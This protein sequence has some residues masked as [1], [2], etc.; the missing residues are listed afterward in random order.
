MDQLREGPPDDE[1]PLIHIELWHEGS[2]PAGV[3]T[4]PSGATRDFTG[5]VGLMSAV[6]ALAAGGEDI[7]TE[8]SR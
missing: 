8:D 1:V 3:A 5:W 2:M 6:E 4:G 7:L